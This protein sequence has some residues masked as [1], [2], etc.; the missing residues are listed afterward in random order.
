M[1]HFLCEVFDVVNVHDI[2]EINSIFD[3]SKQLMIYH[4][5][6]K[7]PMIL[8]NLIFTF[9]YKDCLG[10]FPSKLEILKFQDHVLNSQNNHETFSFKAMDFLVKYTFY[11]HISHLKI[12]PPS[13]SLKLSEQFANELRSDQGTLVKTSIG[14]KLRDR[15]SPAIEI[16]LLHEKKQHVLKHM[17]Q[18]NDVFSGSKETL[19]VSYSKLIAP[20]GLSINQF[21]E[22]NIDLIKRDELCIKNI[23]SNYRLFPLSQK[24][25]KL[26]S[27]CQDSSTITLTD[28]IS[29]QINNDFCFQR[30]IM[31]KPCIACYTKDEYPLEFV[32]MVKEAVIKTHVGTKEAV[33]IIG[34]YHDMSSTC[35]NSQDKHDREDL[36]SNPLNSSEHR[37]YTSNSRLFSSCVPRIMGTFINIVS[38]DGNDDDDD[39]DIEPKSTNGSDLLFNLGTFMK[40]RS[41]FECYQIVAKNSE[42]LASKVMMIPYS[43]T[44]SSRV[45]QHGN[46]CSH[47][48]D[49]ETLNLSID[50]LSSQ[51]PRSKNVL[52]CDKSYSDAMTRDFL[53][54]YL[55]SKTASTP[56]DKYITRTICPVR[57]YIL[58]YMAKNEISVERFKAERAALN[59]VVPFREAENCILYIDNRA[60][61]QGVNNILI[62]MSNLKTQQW[63]VVIMTSNRK[64]VK[65]FYVENLGPHVK[66]I[67]NGIL[68]ASR[69]NIEHYNMIMKDETTWDDLLLLGYKK[70][71][72]IQDDSLLLRRGMEDAF[73]K[74]DYV[75]PPWRKEKGNEPLSEYVS[76]DFVG[77]GGIS[78]RTVKKM[79]HICKTY[80]NEKN[81]LFNGMLQVIPEDVYFS[82]TSRLMGCSL[83]SHE[84]AS[85]FAIEQV[86]NKDALGIHKFW[87]YNS[88]EDVIKYFTSVL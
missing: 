19:F 61:I 49:V 59:T 21:Y 14:K 83:P 43:S 8:S 48:N 24:T 22:A 55:K 63:D 66:F 44:P 46:A 26:L 86:F 42:I 78:L 79:S 29:Y 35:C 75:G 4:K 84:E 60:N 33:S 64:E 73:L 51:D 74:Y 87:V 54:V 13:E 41:D 5:I 80:R 12:R 72:V 31:A 23:F 6:Y 53:S 65:D 3:S 56:R 27:F 69:F 1:D 30:L 36:E 47:S 34:R 16:I 52:L 81:L 50:H 58:R 10:I 77:N 88:Q 9:C 28:C 15:L 68:E 76:T 25:E 67:S 17:K 70:C 40:P 39:D 2:P 11:K 18:M 37:I 45:I 32:D 20:S 82:M 62:T 7:H 85:F 57:N 38:T 71:L